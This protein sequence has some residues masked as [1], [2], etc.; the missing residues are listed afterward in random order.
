ML[1]EKAFALAVYAIG[2]S[3]P[4]PAVG[5]LL[6][7]P[8]LGIIGE[9]FT[10]KPGGLHAERVALENALAAYPKKI[11]SESSLYVTLEPCSHHGKTPPCTTAILTNKLNAVSFVCNDINPLVKGEEVLRENNVKVVS[12]FAE[13]KQEKNKYQREIFWSLQPFFYTQQNKK[14]RAFLKWAQTAEG[15][16]A[17]KIPARK[18]ISNEHSLEAVYRM[19]SLFKAVLVTPN[20]V[21]VDRPRLTAR[22]QS[23]K[24]LKLQNIEQ[25]NYFIVMLHSLQLS[26][27]KKNVTNNIALPNS[28]FYEGDPQR[29]FMIPSHWQAEEFLLYAQEQEKNGGSFFFLFTNKNLWQFCLQKKYAGY[30]L[31][32]FSDLEKIK[33]LVYQNGSL[34]LMIEAGV[35]FSQK[36]LE[37]KEVDGIFSFCSSQKGFSKNSEQEQEQEGKGNSFSLALAK[38]LAKK[39]SPPSNSELMGFQL[40]E[41]LLVGDSANHAD[42]LY[43][44]QKIFV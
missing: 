44:W 38:L 5:A 13:N 41:Q 15:Y 8:Q 25:A 27:N 2:K 18:Q 28:W 43:F 33:K 22:Y 11:I 7:H 32:N 20:T 36:Y 16:L 29:Y 14:A 21:D 40:K 9:G 4:N 23:Q 17:T 10:Q 30:F 6:F 31:E 12:F 24:K 19:R 39:S 37:S 1:F 34:Q 35:G 3:D 26:S 42:T